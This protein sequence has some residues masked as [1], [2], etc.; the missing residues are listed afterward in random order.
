MSPDNVPDKTGSV[1]DDKAPAPE[2]KPAGVAHVENPGLV[3]VAGGIL[4]KRDVLLVNFW[5]IAIL[6]L[7][8][9]TFA[10]ISV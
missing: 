9:L 6:A 3:G 7:V 2:A 8:G 10:A 4:R 1:V 5:I